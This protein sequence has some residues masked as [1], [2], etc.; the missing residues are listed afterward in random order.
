M[1]TA[2]AYLVYGEWLRSEQRRGRSPATPPPGIRPAAATWAPTGSLSGPAEN[3]PPQGQRRRPGQRARRAVDAAS[4]TAQE[5]QIARLAADGLT[6]SEIGAQL[7]ISAFT[8][9]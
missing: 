8:V 7:F 1:L 5:M 6:N 4:L 9:E 2:R 3:S